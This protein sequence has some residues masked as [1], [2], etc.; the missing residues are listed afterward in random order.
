[1]PDKLIRTFAAS[2]ILVALAIGAS[3][4]LLSD[5][6]EKPVE[7]VEQDL[8]PVEAAPTGETSTA[9]PVEQVADDEDFVY[10]LGLLDGVST[11]NFWKYFGSAPTVWDAYILAPT[12]ASLYRV[13]PTTLEI[14]PELAVSLADPTWN[15]DG[16]RT[17]VTLRDDMMWSDGIRMTASDV[18]FTYRTVRSLGLGGQWADV[19]PPSVT[20]VSALDDV[21]VEI[22]FASR[23]SLSTWPY[24]AG[25]APVMA[26]HIWG[27]YLSAGMTPEELFALDAHHDVAGG[28]SEIVEVGEGRIVARANPGY[29]HNNSAPTVE[30]LVFA[31]EDDAVSALVDG[32]VDLLASP[33]GLQPDQVAALAGVDGVATVTNPKFGVRYLSFNTHREPM[34]EVAFRQAVAFLVDRDTLASEVASTPLANTML[35]AAAT[36]WYDTEA[37]AAIAEGYSIEPA[38][39]L[40]AVL[41]AL[42]AAGYTW[43]LEPTWNGSEMVA[44]EGLQI[45]GRPPAALT[46]LTSGDSYDPARPDYAEQIALSIE[47]LGF[48][49]I[50]VTTDFASVV[51]LTFTPDETGNLQYDMVLLGWSLGNPGLPSFYGDL[52]GSKGAANNTGYTSPAMDRLVRMLDSAA[53]D[54]RAREIIWEIEALIA[55]DL[56]YLPLYASQITEAYRSDLVTFPDQQVLGGIQAAFAGIELVTPKP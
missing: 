16:W 37:A 46:I 3:V 42:K 53:D 12:K 6:E 43:S 18:A 8:T 29:P 28:P 2:S 50:P 20:G 48:E 1:M 34:K 23:P 54:E 27:T 36:A 41:A 4:Q 7:I 31:S 39:G 17:I 56:P 15:A 24:G 51:D 32:H 25:T 11:E 22:T 33:N 5:S 9:A 35:P 44:G 14:I 13:D 55:A 19:F 45:Q 26:S 38:E 52:F 10:K 30:Y 47:L 40:A 49:V 21:H